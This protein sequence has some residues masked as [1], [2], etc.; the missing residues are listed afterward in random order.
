VLTL[1]VVPFLGITSMPYLA[2]VHPEVV[3]KGCWIYHTSTSGRKYLCTATNLEAVVFLGV[4]SLLGTFASSRLW[5]IVRYYLQPG[6]QLPD[7]DSRFLKLSQ[8]EA[9]KELWYHIQALRRELSAV[10]SA[11]G[12][13][14]WRKI[15]SSIGTLKG[16]T[17]Q[18]QALPHG[19]SA[20]VPIRFGICAAI[21]S[22]SFLVLDIFIPFF[23]GEGLQEQAV[24]LAYR[25]P[26]PSTEGLDNGFGDYLTDKSM[27]SRVYWDSVRCLDEQ[28][29]WA[30][31][32]YCIRLRD[33]LPTYHK[34]QLSLSLLSEDY[35]QALVQH[36]D[37]KHPALKLAQNLTV[38][39]IGFNSIGRGKKLLHELTC[40]PVELKPFIS[41]VDGKH[42]LNLPAAFLP[43]F[44]V[45]K[46]FRGWSNKNELNF[47]LHQS[48]RIESANRMGSARAKYLTPL[49][50]ESNTS[51]W[52]QTAADSE[53]QQ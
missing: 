44:G 19:M 33:D 4:L 30:G 50:H 38:Q 15:K 43:R 20:N 48:M 46:E 2:T 8:K 27:R 31:E 12:G 11:K 3:Y 13:E 53:A 25:S 35:H 6:V 23:L 5:P 47:T 7:P 16:N 28:L 40:T 41:D 32:P 9:I 18:V 52:Y 22:A 42:Q 29:H 39:D 36:G 45:G 10:W 17:G 24:V 1:E 26:S 37:P 49:H 51:V 34:R 21:T 14:Y